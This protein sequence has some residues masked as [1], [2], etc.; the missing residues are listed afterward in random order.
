MIFD[1]KKRECLFLLIFQNELNAGEVDN[2]ANIIY[3]NVQQRHGFEISAEDKL[4][5]EENFEKYVSIKEEIDLLLAKNIHNWTLDR[6][7]KIEL[8]LLRLYCLEKTDE[9]DKKMINHILNLAHKYGK[10]DSGKFINGVI[11]NINEYETNLL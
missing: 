8:A 10:E 1:K 4:F 3:E 5:I 2:F 9:I 11:K 6:I 7:G